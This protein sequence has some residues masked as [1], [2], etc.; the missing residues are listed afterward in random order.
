[1]Q[2]QNYN[3]HISL[4]SSDAQK[5]KYGQIQDSILSGIQKGEWSPGDKIPSERDLARMFDASVGTVR[6]A[7][8]ALVN[9]GYL[10]RSQG[11][12][13]FVNKSVEHTDS[14]RYFRFASDFEDVVQPLN[15][16]CLQK[17]RP[18]VFPEV[19][20]ILG[21]EPTAKLFEVKRIFRLQQE[22]LVYVTSYL[23]QSLFPDL[24]GI[25][26]QLFH[27][28]PLYLLVERKYSMPTLATK[29]RF[30]AV[31]ADAEVAKMLNLKRGTSVL[32]IMMVASTTRNT[33]YEYQVSYCNTAQRQIYRD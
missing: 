16:K 13:T 26:L 4:F 21:I 1:M 23:P 22:P 17:P 33:Q 27:E 18:G 15:I 10:V 19:S 24:D 11:R 2:Q 12:G 20:K 29:E 3:T 14:L 5:P 32:K 9:Q 25:S 7:M 6:N 31:S 28:I 30:S 8:Q